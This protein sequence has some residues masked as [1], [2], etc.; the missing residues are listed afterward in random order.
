M[1][2]ATST[3]ALLLVA[4]CGPAPCALPRRTAPVAD[5]ANHC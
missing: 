4:V 3:M 1:W 2:M 5:R